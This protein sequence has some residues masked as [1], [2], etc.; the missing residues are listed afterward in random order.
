MQTPAV[1]QGFA[2]QWHWRRLLR[3]LQRIRT[4][5]RAQH[6]R[7]SHRFVAPDLTTDEKH[8][9]SLTIQFARLTPSF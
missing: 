3:S 5:G 4:H 1:L 7:E 2:R 9:I 8:Y 6:R